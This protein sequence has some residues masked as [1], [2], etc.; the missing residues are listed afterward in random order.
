MSWTGLGLEFEDDPIRQKRMKIWERFESTPA[1]DQTLEHGI[2][3]TELSVL[4]G[5]EMRKRLSSLGI[6]HRK[7][8]NK[9]MMLNALVNYWTNRF[10]KGV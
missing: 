7:L 3:I 5:A 1:F 8:K 10:K 6:D 9:T 4:T 2:W